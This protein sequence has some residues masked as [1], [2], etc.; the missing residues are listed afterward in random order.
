MIY[1]EMIK[2]MPGNERRRIDKRCQKISKKKHTKMGTEKEI[3][4]LMQENEKKNHLW[5]EKI[6]SVEGSW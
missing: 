2:I 6:T 5:S 3:N 4:K 1:E